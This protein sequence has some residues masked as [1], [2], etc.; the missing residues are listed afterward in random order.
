MSF[1]PKHNFQLFADA[2]SLP[3]RELARQATPT[4]KVERFAELV[5]IGKGSGT[6][7]MTMREIQERWLAEKVAIRRRQLV[8]FLSAGSQH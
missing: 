5:A 6:P 8:A 1:A 2:T 4:Q 7:K 3:R